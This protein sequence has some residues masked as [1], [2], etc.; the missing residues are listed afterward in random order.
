MAGAE[1]REQNRS[2]DE[3]E[4]QKQCNDADHPAHRVMRQDC[5]ILVRRV[6]RHRACHDGIPQDEAEYRI[7]FAR[8]I[9]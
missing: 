2:A 9:C 1:E 8:G 3:N 7:S 5:W 4:R 6:I